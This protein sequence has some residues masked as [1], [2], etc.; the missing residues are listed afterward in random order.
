MATGVMDLYKVYEFLKRLATPFEK[1][2][3]YKEGIIDKEGNIL[4][5]KNDRNTLD[6]KKAFQIFDLMV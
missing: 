3:A 2:P 4:I 1:W 5:K 6:Q